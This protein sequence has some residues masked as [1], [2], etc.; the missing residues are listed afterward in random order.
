MLI[1]R[2]NTQLRF[3]LILCISILFAMSAAKAE[4]ADYIIVFK[5]HRGR[6]QTAQKASFAVKRKH[7]IIPGLAAR[8]N[9]EQLR[10]LRGN[11]NVAYVEPDYKIFAHDSAETQGTSQSIYESMASSQSVPYGITMVNA[12]QVWDITQGAGAVVAVLDTGISFSHPDRGN[13]IDSVSF[14][15]GEAVEDMNSHGTHTSGIIGAADNDIG[16]VG[17]A[18]EAELL[19][20]KVLAND[21]IGQTSWI[22]AGIEWAVDNGADVISMSL[23]NDVSSAALETACDNAQ[24]SGALLVASAGNSGSSTPEYP[25]SYSSVVSV[26]AMDQNGQKASFSNWGA[27]IELG[28]PGVGVLSTIP[29]RTNATSNAIWNGIGHQTN[30][31]D[32]TTVGNVNGLIYNC[33]LATGAD[34]QNTCPNSVAGNIAHIRRGDITFADKVTHAQS[35]G[36]AGVIISNNVV[37]NFLGTLAGSSDLVVVSVSQADGDNLQALAVNGTAGSVSVTGNFYLARSGTSMSAPHAA[38]V[39]ALI[40]SIQDVNFSPAEVRDILA[41]SAQDL[42]SSG[43]DNIFG[44]GLV[45]ANAAIAML[46]PETC[47]MAWN[48]GFGLAGDIDMNCYVSQADLL[49]FTSE[50]LRTDCNSGNQWC[51]GADIGK[52]NSVS[53]SDFAK[54]A[55]QWTACNDPEELACSPYSPNW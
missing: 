29:L 52:N 34:P 50:W 26:M 51:D 43:W 17:V 11:P 18:P 20:G 42:G 23:G 41:D 31:I 13:V 49:L 48:L 33:G 3:K 22:I 27:T 54:F 39:A 24:A 44:Y 7:H 28:A 40:Y 25:A 30:I 14:V 36:A 47:D 6:D 21:G 32:G 2:L 53:F 4:K 55:A 9:P 45:D 16:V 35:K 5:D 38:G 19:I 37:G 12:P 10:Q 1:E 46:V 8:L 15:P